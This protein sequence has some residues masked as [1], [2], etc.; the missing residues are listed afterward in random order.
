M[1]STLSVE[2]HNVGQLLSKIPLWIL[3]TRRPVPIGPTVPARSRASADDAEHR[4][5]GGDPLELPD[6]S[7]PVHG[8]VRPGTGGQRKIAAQDGPARARLDLLQHHRPPP[9]ASDGRPT[10]GGADVADPVGVLAQ[11]RDEVLLS[12][13][14]GYDQRK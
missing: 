9:A 1:L 7:V 8:K 10:P 5:A 6:R 13:M 4:V 11:H 3:R 2:G 14:V 12:A